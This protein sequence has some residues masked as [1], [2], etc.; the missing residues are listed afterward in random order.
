MPKKVFNK[1]LEKRCGYCIFGRKSEFSNEVMCIK[2]GITDVNDF[3]RK[4]KYDPLKREPERI[5]ISN[6]FNAEDFKI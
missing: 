2:K 1:K 6:D 3:C 4:F 5:R